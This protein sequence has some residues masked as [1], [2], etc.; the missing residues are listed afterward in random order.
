MKNRKTGMLEHIE[1]LKQMVELTLGSDM[2]R[3]SDFTRCHDAIYEMTRR[4]VSIS[5]L[6]RF[7]GYVST[8]NMYMP[9]QYTLDTLAKYVGSNDYDSFCQIQLPTLDMEKRKEVDQLISTTSFHLSKANKGMER[10]RELLAQESN[11]Q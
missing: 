3:P 10:L 2:R 8:N 9:N 4:N 6:K 11:C 5:T 1:Q 7:W